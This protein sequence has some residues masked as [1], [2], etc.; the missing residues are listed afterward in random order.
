[1]NKLEEVMEMN[2]SDTFMGKMKN[3]MCMSA[4]KY[5]N[6]GNMQGM[7]ALDRIQQEIEVFME[8]GNLEH[9]VNVA[10]WAMMRFM[11]P[12]EGERYIGTDSNKSTK[13]EYMSVSDWLRRWIM[14]N[15]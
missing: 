10:N 11:F 5:G 7:K 6:V 8:D 2:V 14:E 15:D 9:M 4:F 13:K 12:Q 3:A 1:M